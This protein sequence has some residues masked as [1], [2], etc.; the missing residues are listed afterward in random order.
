LHIVDGLPL[1]LDFL[2]LVADAPQSAVLGLDE[3]QAQLQLVD[4]L[5]HVL[6]DLFL[7]LLG[8]LQ[9]ADVATQ[10]GDELRLFLECS[11]SSGEGFLLLLECG[12]DVNHLASRCRKLTLQGGVERDERAGIEFVVI[13][14]SA[15]GCRRGCIP[16]TT[17]LGAWHLGIAQTFII[18]GNHE[19]SL[20]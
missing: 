8:R 9:L 1:A 5:G 17:D 3:G 12:L 11:L 4:V 16:S 6:L 14:Y 15:V 10:I 18:F 2:Y 7:R 19:I 13:R 20:S